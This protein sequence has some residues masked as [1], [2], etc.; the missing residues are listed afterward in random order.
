MDHPNIVK[1]YESF[2]DQNCLFIA[3]EL[4][5]GMSLQHYLNHLTQQN[6]PMEEEEIW[7]VFLQICLAL[8]YLHDVKRVVHRDLTPSNI[9]IG[10]SPKRVKVTDFGLARKKKPTSMMDSVVGTMHYCCPE[11]V[12]H[13]KYTEKADIWSLG[14]ILYAMLM[15]RSPFQGENPLAVASNIVEAKYEPVADP[16]GVSYSPELRELVSALLVPDPQQRPSIGTVSKL[17]ATR[18]MLELDRLHRNEEVLQW[19]LSAEKSRHQQTATIALKTREALHKAGS[20]MTPRAN[21]ALDVMADGSDFGFSR[22]RVPPPR[23]AVTPRSPMSP[24]KREGG[25]KISIAQSKLR[26]VSDPLPQV[27]HQLQ[28]LLYID[29]LP[30]SLQRDDRRKYVKAYKRMLFNEHQNVGSLKS[31][32]FKLI[33]ATTD[34]VELRGVRAQNGPL[35]SEFSYESLS[36]TIEEILKETD[37]YGRAGPD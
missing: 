5:E 33:S 23:D 24:R 11:I 4:V 30:P 3:M 28:K 36:Q 12:Q 17:I 34:P 19:Q 26:P 31:E 6:R 27:L 16:P 9:M 10:S 18:M 37:F 8:R 25:A 35:E 2:V 15:L 13:T 32:L 22:S 7:H 1:Y 21:Q 29:Q 20:Q 14:C